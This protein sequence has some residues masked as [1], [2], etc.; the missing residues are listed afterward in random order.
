MALI[1]IGLVWHAASRHVIGLVWHAASRHVMNTLAFAPECTRQ[2]CGCYLMPSVGLH[3]LSPRCVLLLLQKPAAAA[4]ANL[5]A[6][7]PGCIQIN[8]VPGLCT[9][10]QLPCTGWLAHR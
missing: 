1:G 9:Q 10:I 2:V 6:G 8:R 7:T 4:I 3:L 5:T